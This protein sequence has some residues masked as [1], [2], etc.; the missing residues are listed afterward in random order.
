[1]GT[2]VVDLF[3]AVVGAGAIVD[4]DGD[5]VGA[6]ARLVTAT[7]LRVQESSLTG[8][9]EATTKEPA[10]LH[11]EASI[12]DRH[13]MVHKG[14]AVVQGVGR[15]VVTATGMDTEM[16][17]IADMLER[18][19]AEE[20]PLQKEIAAVSRSLGL[21]VV[22]VAVVVARDL[23]HMAVP[24]LGVAAMIAGI[25]VPRGKHYPG[26][27]VAGAVL[28]LVSALVVRRLWDRAARD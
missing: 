28:G 3:Q 26:D 5:A 11:A 25:Q 27:V 20:T 9:S 8:E 1:M 21:L 17:A 18:T 19:R 14:T 23:P 24:A 22:A 4:D 13:N 10:T 6:D 12:G 15:A 16:G 2:L 7:G